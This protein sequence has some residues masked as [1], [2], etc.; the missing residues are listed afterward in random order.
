MKKT[1]QNNGWS[2]FPAAHLD[3]EGPVTIFLTNGVKLSGRIAIVWDDGLCLYR[4]G[5]AQM[6]MAH[7]VSTIMPSDGVSFDDL[8]EDFGQPDVKRN[9]G[10]W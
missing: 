2:V 3:D 10:R 5:M 6:V 8:L 1:K 4:D 9:G 7:A